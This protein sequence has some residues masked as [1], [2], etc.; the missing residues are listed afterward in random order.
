MFWFWLINQVLSPE[1]RTYVMIKILNYLKIGI[2]CFDFLIIASDN[3]Q[4]KLDWLKLSCAS[5]TR[6][7]DKAAILW[8]SL[9][10]TRC[11]Q[12]MKRPK[13][14]MHTNT[15]PSFI[16]SSIPKTN[17]ALWMFSPSCLFS[18]LHFHPLPNLRTQAKHQSANWVNTVHAIIYSMSDIRKRNGMELAL[19]PGKSIKLCKI[20]ILLRNPL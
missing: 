10:K 3:F 14:K 7:N 15:H 9:F 13:M 19:M 4:T 1:W 12:Q 17:T 2:K 11:K 20:I 16:C 18:N 6:V 8:K 5:L